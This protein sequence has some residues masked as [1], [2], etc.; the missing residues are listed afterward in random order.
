MQILNL[1]QLKWILVFKKKE[2]QAKSIQAQLNFTSP[3]QKFEL[4]LHTYF[5]LKFKLECN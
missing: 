5:K 1:L 4:K 3:Q 2:K